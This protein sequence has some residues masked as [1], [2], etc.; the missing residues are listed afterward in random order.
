MRTASL[1]ALIVV[2]A[3]EALAFSVSPT[4][5]AER[6]VKFKVPGCV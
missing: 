1:C 5:G 3:A 4:L 2:G 6:T